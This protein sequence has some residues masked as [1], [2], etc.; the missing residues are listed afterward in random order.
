MT[1]TYQVNNIRRTKCS[2][3]GCRGWCSHPNVPGNQIVLNEDN[4]NISN[5]FRRILR[6]NTKIVTFAWDINLNK[7]SLDWGVIFHV[8]Q[9]SKQAFTEQRKWH[10]LSLS[11]ASR[12]SKSVCSVK[13]NLDRCNGG[14]GTELANV[15]AMTRFCFIEVLFIYI[16][17]Y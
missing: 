9:K 13:W 4:I 15:F 8:A 7:I 2:N 1:T 17:C 10:R 3:S 6:W 16:F 12:V 14:K 5:E 11:K